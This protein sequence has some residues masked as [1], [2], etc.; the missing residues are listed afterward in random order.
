MWST[1]LDLTRIF[2]L[3]S[4]VWLW[5]SGPVCT[6]RWKKRTVPDHQPGF[7]LCCDSWNS[8]RWTDLWYVP[9]LYDRTQIWPQLTKDLL[10]WNLG[11]PESYCL[12]VGIPCAFQEL[13]AALEGCSRRL[14]YLGG[15]FTGYGLN[16]NLSNIK[17]DMH[18][19]LSHV[20]WENSCAVAYF[21]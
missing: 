11:P 2:F 10:L 19:N 3:L 7:W 9:E 17:A 20:W 13:R 4:G 6:Q 14:T 15:N 21:A 16:M 5:F 18:L 8:D 1:K 12:W